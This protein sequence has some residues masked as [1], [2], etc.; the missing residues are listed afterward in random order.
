MKIVVDGKIPFI[1]GVFEPFAEV[2]Y[3]PGRE[4]DRNMVSDA[5]A[6]IVRTRTKCNSHLLKGSKVK[7]VA[8]ATIGFDHLETE[9]LESEGIKWVNSPGCNSGSV[10]Q[11]IVAALFHLA[12][13]HNLNLPD[14]TLGVV[15][16]GNVGSKVVDAAR[17]I[18]MQ[19]LQND[20]PRKRREGLSDFIPLDKLLS[21]SDIV[22]L[23][24]PLTKEGYD[25]T[26]YLINACNLTTM[27][28]DCILINSSR[29]EIVDN[30]ALRK[31]LT[32]NLIA[33]AVLDVW[34][35]EPDADAKLIRLTD[36]A[37]PHIAGYSVDG[38]ANATIRV[39][40]E[41]STVLGIPLKDWAPDMLPEPESPFIDI[42]S[43]NKR[44]SST[45]LVAIAVN[46]TYPIKED[47]KFFRN[48]P[49]Q[50]ESLRDNYRKRRE[51]G[52]YQV[53]VKDENAGRILSNLGFKIK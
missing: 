36:I 50:F 41:V 6:L 2:I 23:H 47:D 21:S 32:K 9:W 28:S 10:M 52:S 34:E 40:R 25:K 37:T 26:H 35:G 46:H 31:A 39:V 33:G 17:A 49:D 29:G 38:K 24:V 42:D 14:L 16:V 5:D 27:K 8:S 19:V 3:S 53:S 11:Y 43:E 1:K 51:F 22:T 48:D 18:G 12:S 20:P 4:I 30:I 15:G 7:I 44:L 45:D 13:K